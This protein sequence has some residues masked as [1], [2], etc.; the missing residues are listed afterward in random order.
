[1]FSAD[2]HGPSTL[3]GD[4]VLIFDLDGTILTVNSFPYWAMYMLTGHFGGLTRRERLM[5]TWRTGRALLK[6]KLLRENHDATK[7]RLQELWASSLLKDANQTA[8]R[9]LNAILQG[10]IRTNLHSVLQAVSKKQVDAL[11]ATSAADEYA[12]ALGRA[13]GFEHVLTTPSCADPNRLENCRERK[14]DRVL[15]TLKELG[16]Q[17]RMRIFFT[18]HAEDMPLMKECHLTLWFG[19]YDEAG[20]IKAQVPETQVIACRH[21]PDADVMRLTRSRQSAMTAEYRLVNRQ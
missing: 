15:S 14:R 18:D 12:Q 19:T 6:R 8:I 2:S 21:L 13:L 3:R 4:A 10:Y 17:N 9:C 1:M 20:A 16:W 11:L 7:S 5:L